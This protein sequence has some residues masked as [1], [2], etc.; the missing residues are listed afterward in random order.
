[1]SKVS[2]N[3]FGETKLGE[4]SGLLG[5]SPEQKTR[6]R[7]DA[8]IQGV[9]ANANIVSQR[10]ITLSWPGEMSSLCN[11]LVEHLI[12]EYTPPGRIFS[13]VQ[14]LPGHIHAT[15]HIRAVRTEVSV[16]KVL[17]A[18]MVSGSDPLRWVT[19]DLP[20]N[21]PG[22]GAPECNPDTPLYLANKGVSHLS[23]FENSGQLDDINK[24]IEYTSRALALSR[25]WD[26]EVAGI[27]TILGVAYGTRFRYLGKLDDL[28]KSI[29]YTSGAVHDPIFNPANKAVCL[30]NLGMAYADRFKR[31]EKLDDAKKAIEYVSR[32]IELTPKGDPSL[33]QLLNNLGV[34]YEDR[35]VRLGEVDD[36]DKSIEYKHCA[37][38]LA[39][40]DHPNMRNFYNNLGVA[41]ADRYR[42]LK[43]LGDL[44]KSIKY[45]SRAVELTPDDHPDKPRLL[46][47]LGVSHAARFQLL[48]ELDDLDKSIENK[49]SAVKLTPEEHQDM[50]RRLRFLGES[51]LQRFNFL[52]GDKSAVDDLDKSIEC[53][54]RAKKLIP[55]GHPE[56]PRLL[57]ELGLAQHCRFQCLGDMDDFSKAMASSSTA[58]AL[59][60]DGDPQSS[61]Q[62]FIH[63]L[64][65]LNCYQILG[66]A[67]HLEG[68]LDSFR[69]GCHLSNGAPRAIFN[70]ALHWANLASEHQYLNPLEAF[71]TAI[72]LLPRFIWLGATTKQRYL[73]LSTAKTLAVNASHVAV[74]AS[75][76]SLAVEWLE[77]ARCV[78]WSQSLMLRSPVDQLHLSHP[79]LATQLEILSNQLYASGFD[80]QISEEAV[81]DAGRNERFEQQRHSLAKDY[82]SLLAEIRQLAGF[83][84]FLKPPKIDKLIGAAKNGPVVIVICHSDR[85]DALVILPNCDQVGHVPLHDFN[86]QKAHQALSDL[87]NSL[88]PK[89]LRQRGFR[90]VE[91][92]PPEE[93]MRRVLESL[94]HGIVRPVLDYLEY[95]DGV[96]PQRLPHI[97]WCPTGPLSFL[98]LHAAGDYTQSQARVFKYAVSS[99]TPTLSALLTSMPRSLDRDCRVL[100]VGQA[101]TPDCSS[102]PG[103]T[104]ELG[105][106]RAHTGDKAQLKELVDDQATKMAVLDAMQRHD[107]VHLACH[108]YQDRKDPTKSGFRLHDG[109]LYLSAINQRLFKNKGL[110][111][112][113]ACETATGD[114]ELPDEAI[115]LAS[116]MLMAGYPSVIATMWPLSDTHAPFVANK[117]YGQLMKDGM[118]EKGQAGRALHSA[119]AELR[120]VV[121]EEAFFNWVPYIHIGS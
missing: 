73:D 116:G 99:Y 80:E 98:P 44:N 15:E 21:P 61:A 104:E 40:E 82:Q 41:Y 119:V 57:G 20:V 69:K 108:A 24:S 49:S 9:K 81:I 54:S 105:Y 50:P 45:K 89:G 121:G 74:I 87:K 5:E 51:Y 68:C 76:F 11:S 63:G 96:P 53:Y 117:V 33:P 17:S 66:T 64:Y 10:Q 37:I 47:N 19:P 16:S 43:E 107:W 3:V 92:R 77:H 60:P 109:P 65:F 110:A 34:P 12:S 6:S 18:W 75:N 22:K 67:A 72:D 103:T 8:I 59:T 112:L 79:A 86:E 2:W 46:T 113:S 1:M 118:I 32:A 111:F 115:H 100:A 26:H 48:E 62:H 52:E 23:Q 94:W 78:V 88:Q 93:Y 55:K 102:L 85:C 36:I 70:H 91:Q 38:A 14:P 106:L 42:H 27:L 4:S 30:N 90:P 83:E 97:T 58:L 101:E 95:T 120:E 56:M 7:G 25:G 84:D 114:E 28:E 35:F 39:P 71:Q 13:R 29:E 31:L